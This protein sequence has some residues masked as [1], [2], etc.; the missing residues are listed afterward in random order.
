MLEM[1]YMVS[2]K[3]PSNLI[4]CLCFSD[5]RFLVPIDC[6]KHAAKVEDIFVSRPNHSRN[7]R[8]TVLHHLTRLL[9]Y[10][11]QGL[12]GAKNFVII[13]SYEWH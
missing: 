4:H 3:S 6:E 2:V 8:I 5:R 10:K 1:L 7:P 13:F 11:G 9:L 12:D